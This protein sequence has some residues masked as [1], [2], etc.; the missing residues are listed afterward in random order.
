MYHRG[1]ER[2]RWFGGI[3][4]RL[5]DEEPLVMRRFVFL[6][7]CLRNLTQPRPGTLLMVFFGVRL[8]SIRA[9]RKKYG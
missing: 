1:W 3:S 5:K 8:L 4:P 7:T 9:E 2:L 6:V